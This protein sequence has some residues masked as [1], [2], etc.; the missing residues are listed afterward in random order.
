[1][2]AACCCLNRA[3]LLLHS[4]YSFLLPSLPHSL[5]ALQWSQQY[6]RETCQPL[7]SSHRGRREWDGG[8]R[9]T[10]SAWCRLSCNMQD[11]EAD[12][13]IWD[14]FQ[15]SWKWQDRQLMKSW[16]QQRKKWKN[17]RKRDAEECCEWVT[18]KAKSKWMNESDRVSPEPLWAKL[19]GL[20][21][22]AEPAL[23]IWKCFTHGSRTSSK[24]RG[25]PYSFQNNKCQI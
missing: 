1:M 6:C 21:V 13:R 24:C 16:Q 15:S 12:L 5:T 25:T 4:L 9:G 23:T 14:L 10:D 22:P 7:W 19:L 11:I 3:E 17:D 20:A 2:G 8:K 18:K